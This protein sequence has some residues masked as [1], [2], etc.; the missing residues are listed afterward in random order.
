METIADKLEILNQRRNY[1]IGPNS[2]GKTHTLKEVFKQNED[3][4]L[5]FDEIGEYSFLKSRNKVQIDNN[6]YVY[7]NE[8][9]RGQETAKLPNTEEINESSFSIIKKI[10]DIQSKIIL[11]SNSSGIT[12]LKRILDVLLTMNLNSIEIVIFDEP[13]NFLD[14]TNLKYIVDLLDSF[15][16]ADIQI[17]VATHSARFLELSSVRIGELFVCSISLNEGNIDY[18]V[19]NRTMEDIKDLYTSIRDNIKTE[20][21]DNGH[22]TDFSNIFK[23]ISLLNCGEP[24]E[25]YEGDFISEGKVLEL[26]LNTIIE[27]FEFYQTLLYRKVIIVEGLTEKLILQKVPLNDLDYQNFY[28]SN[29]KIH[30]PFYI[31]LFKF[32][33]LNVV[34]MFD[35]DEAPSN[36]T[37]GSSKFVYKLTCYLKQKYLEDTRVKLIV[38]QSKDLEQDYEVNQILDDFSDDSG[39]KKNKLSGDNF[40]KPYIASFCFEENNWKY[41][42]L[43]RKIIGEDDN[44]RFEFN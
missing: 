33:G 30:F 16:K 43:S 1:L 6:I 23:K 17:F 40:F 22:T 5:F 38:S 14:E 31:E 35:S 9:S 27:S 11:K 32:F 39:I 3:T 41:D 20:I 2:S 13:E 25:H 44:N 7:S 8:Q 34:A 15:K 28:F 4:T 26:Y 29:G 10:R 18:K 21:I 36:E 19:T 42:H 37:N 12:K 24:N